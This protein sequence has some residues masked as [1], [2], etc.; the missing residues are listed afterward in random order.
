MATKKSKI[1]KCILIGFDK[2]RGIFYKI[3]NRPRI[4]YDNNLALKFYNIKYNENEFLI[5]RNLL[6]C[7]TD[8]KMKLKH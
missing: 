1:K 2:L 8:I 5:Y 7:N 4:Y 6:F 3:L